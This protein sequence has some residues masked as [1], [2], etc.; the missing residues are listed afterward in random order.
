MKEN[1]EKVRTTYPERHIKLF[2]EEDAD[3][4]IK[5]EIQNGLKAEKVKVGE[6]QYRVYRK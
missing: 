3:L 5:H 2:S 1:D 6:N 4:I